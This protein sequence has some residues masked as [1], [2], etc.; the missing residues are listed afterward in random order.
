MRLVTPLVLLLALCASLLSCAAGAQRHEVLTPPQ[1]ERDYRRGHLPPGSFIRRPTL[2]VAELNRQI[3]EDPVVAA[4]YAHIFQISPEAVRL[5]CRNL[6][7]TRLP[8]DEVMRV[9]YVHGDVIGYKLRRVRAGEPVFA[10]ANGTPVLVQVCG[11]PLRASLLPPAAAL[12]IP[13]FKPYEEVAPVGEMVP[14]ALVE[15][16]LELPS[17]FPFSPPTP[18]VVAEVAP[19]FVPETA[20]VAPAVYSSVPL[21]P[22]LLIPVFAGVGGGGTSPHFPVPPGPTPAPAVP[23]PGPIA[24]AFCAAAAGAF[25]WRV[26]KQSS[27]ISRQ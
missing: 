18:P 19:G 7:A 6:V 27:V 1:L 22:L 14:P 12:Q 15:R 8:H 5:A 13:Y 25:L 9:Y 21:F 24:M 4:R 2:G 10:L 17:P 20:V 16:P 23:E 11:N 26:R 3:A